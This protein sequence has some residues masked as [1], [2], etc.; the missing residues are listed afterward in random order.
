MSLTFPRCRHCN[1]LVGTRV[2]RGLCRKCWNDKGTRERYC[3]VATFGGHTHRQL[4]VLKEYVESQDSR[5]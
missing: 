5:R 2:G 1:D 3:P 4:K